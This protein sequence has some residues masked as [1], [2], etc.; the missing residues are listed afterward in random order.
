MHAAY[1]LYTIII[2][3]IYIFARNILDQLHDVN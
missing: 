3:L 1:I 2:Y